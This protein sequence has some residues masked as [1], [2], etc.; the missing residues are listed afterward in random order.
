MANCKSVY[1]PREDSTLIEK[2]VKLHAHGSVLDIGTGSGIQAI[3]AAHSNKVKSVIGIDIQKGVID[4]CIKNIK[5]KKI[6]FLQS[7]LFDN[8]KNNKF[9][10]IIFNPPYLPQELKIKDLTVEGGKK[11][12][13][14]VERFLDDVND[15]LKEDGIILLL[16]SSLTKKEKVDEFISNN[17]LESELLE[18]EHNF[19]EDLYVY[20]IKKTSLLKKLENK[21][22]KN[23][24]FFNKGKRGFIYTGNH[25]NKKIIIKIKNPKS[26]ALSK[27]ENE[28]NNLLVLNKKGI[29]PKLLISDKDYFCMEFIEGDL[30]TQ[31]LE[32]NNK[33]NIKKIINELFNQLFTMDKLKTNKEEMSHP[34]KHILIDKNNNITLIDFERCRKRLH[35]SNVTQFCDYISSNNIL[36][37]LRNKNIKVNKD[38]LILLAKIYKK[39]INGKNLKLIL[40]AIK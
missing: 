28:I 33:K 7:D 12:Y 5:N 32:K 36:T 13:E 20:L 3:A 22:I 31:F 26:K 10:T 30:F 21:N 14:V 29:G 37:L 19:F 8:L 2:Y 39:N 24:R 34:Q 16:F 23:I 6:K 38:K 25:K 27:I 15:Y 40:N 17:L 1:E 11:G 35:P 18:K 4:H 9:D